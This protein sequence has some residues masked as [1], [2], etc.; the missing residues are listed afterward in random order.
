MEVALVLGFSTDTLTQPPADENDASHTSTPQ[1]ARRNRH[2]RQSSAHSDFEE[3]LQLNG[4]SSSGQQQAVKNLVRLA[5]ASEFSRTSL[6]RSDI[7]SKIQLQ[8]SRQFKTIFEKAQV[9]LRATFGMELVELPAKDRV[10]MTQKRAAAKSQSQGAT[11]SSNRS[12]VLSSVLP[13][14]FRRIVAE[15]AGPSKVPTTEIEGSYTGLYTFVVSLIMLAG[16]QLSEAKLDRYLKRCNADE[17][18]PVDRTDKLLARM[19]KDGYIFKNRDT[20]GGEQVTDY[21]VGP[22]GKLE[23]GEHGVG[24]LVKKVYNVDDETQEVSSE[25]N[26]RLERSLRMATASTADT[27]TA[28]GVANGTQRNNTQRKGKQGAKQQEAE[29]YDDDGDD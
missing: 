12:W 20:S 11:S 21:F 24:G 28:N 17:T 18:T 27:Q 26:R 19:C 29:D 23:V 14:N 13:E 1:P 16:G 15:E 25:L 4:G 2:R 7:P 22:R 9:V 5:L 6:K 10:T 8:D 3:N